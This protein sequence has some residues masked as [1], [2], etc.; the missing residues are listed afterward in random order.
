MT[1]PLC[2][3]KKNI[4]QRDSPQRQ[5]RHFECKDSTLPPGSLFSQNVRGKKPLKL[6]L[7]RLDRKEQHSQEEEND[8]GQRGCEHRDPSRVASLQAKGKGLHPEGHPHLHKRQG[9]EW[10]SP[11]LC[12]CRWLRKQGQRL[13]DRVPHSMPAKQ[14]D[15]W[16]QVQGGVQGCF[17]RPGYI[18]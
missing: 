7:E 1:W 11:W 13:P 18:C 16:S 6:S 8:H 12:Q 14:D 3:M 2:C 15:P 9:R 10:G 17:M 4:F 5:S